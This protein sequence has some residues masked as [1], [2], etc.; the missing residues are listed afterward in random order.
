MKET[1]ER[2]EILDDIAPCG[3]CC[4]TCAAKKGGAIEESAARLNCYLEGYYEFTKT[5]LPFKY[6][7]YCKRIKTLTNELEHLSSRKCGGCRSGA[8]EKCCIPDC[9]ILQCAE[10]HGVDFCGE[11][12]EFPC[13]K[14]GSSLKGITLKEWRSNNE[15]IKKNGIE[16]YYKFAVSRSHYSFYKEK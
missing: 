5:N 7:A 16:E 4:F 13:N 10:T 12:S 3:F 2:S 1:F 6:R 14:A 9:V 8:D 15:M 11:C